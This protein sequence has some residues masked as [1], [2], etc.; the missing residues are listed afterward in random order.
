MVVSFVCVWIW[1]DGLAS[2][3]AMLM[4]LFVAQKLS[5]RTRKLLQL[6]EWGMRIWNEWSSSRTVTD[7][8]GVVP[9]ATPLTEMSPTDLAYW[10]GNFV[11]EVR[12]RDGKPYPPKYLYA[13]VCC[14]KRFCEHNRMYGIN[15]LCPSDVAF[16]DFRAT[17]DAEIKRL[18]GLGL[19]TT[20]KQAQP[21]T[22]EALLWTSRQLGTHSAKSILN[23]VYY[24]NC[25]VFGLCSID[26]HRDLQCSQ[27][28]KR[29]DENGKLYFEYTD[30]GNKTNRGG[31]KRGS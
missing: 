28:T 12:K 25:K 4:R 16:G 21:I 6:G 15:P 18:H 17:L 7:R 23:S 2:Q 24:H 29:L 31:L 20:T 14:F 8:S 22:P 1:Q 9:L 26:E 5:L 11:L 27:Y 3:S 13:L 10:M 30:F 19:G